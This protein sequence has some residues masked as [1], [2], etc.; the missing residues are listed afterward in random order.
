MTHDLFGKLFRYTVLFL[1]LTELISLL[2]Y[3]IPPLNQVAFFIII[4]AV[5][6]ITL[7]KLEYGLY[8]LLA[9]L[10]IG[11][12]GYLFSLNIN[13]TSISIRIGIFLIVL[14]VWLAQ[15]I[16]GINRRACSA[17]LFRSKLWG[18]V[19]FLAPRLGN[20]KSTT[21]CFTRS[22]SP[23]KKRLMEIRRF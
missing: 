8:L 22:T 4:I 17:H 11:G 3:I 5:L 7:I 1:I 20:K 19:P 21:F 15:K 23:I 16:K 18:I 10:F 6:I 12:H 14:A 9:E 13:G 2:T